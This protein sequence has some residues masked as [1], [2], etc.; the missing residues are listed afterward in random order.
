MKKPFSGMRLVICGKGGSGKSTVVAFIAKIL[1]DKGYTIHVLDAD[2]S[3]PG[4]SRLMGFD[5]PES[6]I[7]YYGGDVF[8]GGAVTCPVDDPS[9]LKKGKIS[10]NQLPSNY[11][12]EKDGIYFYKTGEMSN[13]FGGCDGPLDKIA[14]DFKVSITGNPDQITLLDIKA[15][16]EHFGRGVET[17]V[18]GIITIVDPNTTSFEIAKTVKKIVEQMQRG[19]LP[20]TKHLETQ[21]YINIIKKLSD[22]AKNIKY[23]WFILNKVSS[24]KI[25]AKMKEGLKKYGVKPIGSVCYDKD[26]INFSLDGTPLKE[27]K[28]KKDVEKIVKKIDNMLLK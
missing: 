13:I 18:D 17:Y 15:G 24:K 6:L 9:P 2:P 3:N 19:A 22:L 21:E 26:V 8:S 4:L 5:E 10:L 25:E 1:R 16:L 20:A 14:R 12:S 11:Y 27:C 28:A 23:S 7:K